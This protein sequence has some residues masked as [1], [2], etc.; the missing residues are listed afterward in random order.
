MGGHKKEGFLLS[1]PYAFGQKA[2]GRFGLVDAEETVFPI[3]TTRTPGVVTGIDLALSLACA[4]EFLKTL[5]EVVD[6]H[7]GWW[8][9]SENQWGSPLTR[10][11]T[12]DLT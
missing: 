7:D 4:S 9:M 1:Q 11:W 2:L 5:D 6:C 3:A 8:L 10:D 12:P